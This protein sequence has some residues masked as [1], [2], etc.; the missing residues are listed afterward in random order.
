MTAKI[1]PELKKAIDAHRA[2][3]ASVPFTILVWGS[4]KRS[5][6]DYEKRVKIRDHLRQRFGVNAVFFSENKGFQD[7]VEE[8]GSLEVAEE[9]QARSVNAIIVLDTSIG[10]HSEIFSYRAVL[11]R[12]GLVFAREGHVSSGGFPGVV[13]EALKVEEYTAV[14]YQDCST[15]RRKANKFCQALRLEKWRSES[16]A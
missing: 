11:R 6:E 16:K 3:L 13:F 14:E 7:L 8:Y 5:P 1:P 9:I 4:G 10:P 15:I 12:K 2:E